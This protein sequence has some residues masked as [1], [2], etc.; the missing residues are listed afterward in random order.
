MMRRVQPNRFLG[1]IRQAAF[2]CAGGCGTRKV[3]VLLHPLLEFFQYFLFII[4]QKRIIRFLFL[5]FV[6]L[7]KRELNGKTMC[8]V[9][10]KNSIS[11]YS[12]FCS[13]Q[14]SLRIKT[15]MRKTSM[16]I[17]FVYNIKPARK[18]F[19][20]FLFFPSNLSENNIFVIGQSLSFGIR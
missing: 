7:F 13:P 16:P 17:I 5:K 18:C 3:L 6:E 8:S 4:S 1:C 15:T 2:K 11:V 20:K 19:A 14:I 10:I 9:K 12:I